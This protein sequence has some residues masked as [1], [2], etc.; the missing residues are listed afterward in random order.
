[1][2]ES[3]GLILPSESLLVTVSIYCASRYS[4]LNIHYIALSAV[5]GAIMG[6]N[7]GYLIGR[8]VGYPILKK[9][10]PKFK[11]TPERL[12][13]G[14]YLFKHHGGKAVFF[15]RFVAIL[16]FFTALLAGA[17]HMHWKDFLLYNAL[18]GICWACTYTYAAYFLGQEFLKLK[19]IIGISIGS[20]FVIIAVLMFRFLRN[21]ERKLV[22]H[23]EQELKT[24]MDK[25]L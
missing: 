19:G 6:D 24:D 5:I 14:E 13:L 1:M 2:L 25:G 12:L 10:G 16:R 8:K 7:F 22:Q 23:A 18:G 15:G 21:N 20:V 4:S 9:Y 11:L 3:M 17:S